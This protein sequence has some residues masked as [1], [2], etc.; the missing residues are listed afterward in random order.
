M[1]RSGNAISDHR[2]NLRL[3]ELDGTEVTQSVDRQLSG[4]ESLNCLVEARRSIEYKSYPSTGSRLKADQLKPAGAERGCES[5]IVSLVRF[6]MLH[7]G[8]V[9]FCAI[10][11]GACCLNG[12]EVHSTKQKSRFDKRLSLLAPVLFR[13]PFNELVFVINLEKIRNSESRHHFIV[14][15]SGG[16]I[17]R[18]PFTISKI[19]YHSVD[20]FAER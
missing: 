14:D 17:N 13:V 19:I 12:E 4:P 7:N 3:E 18:P 2:V 5:E 11:R 6:F 15:S 8:A 20:L 9:R 1:A 10:M 16:I